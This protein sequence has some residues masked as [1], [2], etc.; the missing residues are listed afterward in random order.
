MQVAQ[1]RRRW[2]RA[3]LAYTFGGLASAILVGAV[4]GT[5]GRIV[6]TP[7]DASIL[8]FIAV[9]SLLCA[10]REARWLTF[11]VPQRHVQTE[12]RWAMEFGI[13]P[14][15]AMWGFHI[16]LGVATRVSFSGFWV[17]VLTILV[18]R[19]PLHGALLMST[20]WLGRAMPVVIAPLGLAAAN[21]HV[22]PERLQ[23]L[24]GRKDIWRRMQVSGL[25]WWC[26]VTAA[27]AAG[28]TG[29]ILPVPSGTR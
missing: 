2:V 4:L 6:G 11:D 9:V 20:Y 25:L 1:D 24:Y 29:A 3:V 18:L 14:G 7:R 15:A 28:Y 12:P 13:V 5:S 27:V 10:A 19:E 23:E 21:G 17:V 22:R 16:G 8:W 26:A